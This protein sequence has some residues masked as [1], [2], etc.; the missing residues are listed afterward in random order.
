VVAT[1]KSGYALRSAFVHHG[2]QVGD[3][4]AADAML[5]VAWRTL[6]ALLDCARRY[7]DVNELIK[8]LEDRKLQ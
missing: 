5:M 8:V 4:V 2:V 1:V 3:T 6:V 7:R